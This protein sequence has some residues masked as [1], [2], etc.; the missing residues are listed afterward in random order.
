MDF[1]SEWQFKLSLTNNIQIYFHSNASGNCFT[2]MSKSFFFISSTTFCPCC[3]SSLSLLPSPPVEYKW[4]WKGQ[5]VCQENSQPCTRSVTGRGRV[6]P[7][8]FIQGCPRAHSIQSLCWVADSVTNAWRLNG[9]VP[10][11]A[12]RLR[13]NTW[14][15]IVLPIN[16]LSYLIFPPAV[17]FPRWIW[18]PACSV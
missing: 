9:I 18:P 3:P 11:D 4:W 1:S 15:K 5:W 17:S 12:Q 6:Q 14:N 7:W 13:S 8:V 16:F 10:D 2:L